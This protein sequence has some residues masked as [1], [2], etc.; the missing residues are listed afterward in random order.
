MGPL[1]I[2]RIGV[3]LILGILL[4]WFGGRILIR[5][6][7]SD[8]TLIRWQIEAMVEGFNTRSM[9]KVLGGIAD[10]F[11]DETSR[12][13]KKDLHA[14]LVHVFMTEIDHLTKSFALRA[15]LEKDALE[16]SLLSDSEATVAASIRIVATHS[17]S[18]TPYWDLKLRA[19]MKKLDGDWRFKKTTEVN[20]P[21]RRRSR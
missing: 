6:L 7:A 17:N 3:I 12:T 1:V 18:E 4:V 14:A 10:D 20:H 19:Q 15:D 5:S 9:G 11:V 13:R 21:S 8:E 16:I 2:T